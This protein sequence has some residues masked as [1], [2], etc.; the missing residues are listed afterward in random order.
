MSGVCE[1]LATGLYIQH[2]RHIRAA[3]TLPFEEE[4]N[5]LALK[6]FGIDAKSIHFHSYDED[7]HKCGKTYKVVAQLRLILW[8]RYCR[9]SARHLT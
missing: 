3:H 7:G 4:F 1:I 9:H 8:A 5:E 2:A 6:H